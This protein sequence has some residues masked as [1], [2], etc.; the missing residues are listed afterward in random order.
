M[1]GDDRGDAAG[2]APA[3]AERKPARAAAAV[4][5]RAALPVL[6][7]AGIALLPVPNGLAANAWLYFAVFAAVIL[8]LITEPIPAAG[9]GLI[10]VTFIAVTGLA[11][12]PAQLAEPA[13]K[14][15]AEA[16]KWALAGFGNSTVWLI[17]GAFVFAMGYEKTGLGRRIALGLVRRLG[18]RTIG[19]GYAIALADVVLAPFTPSNTAR[20]A[21]TIF[22]VIRSIPE[23]Y[24]SHPGA[25]ARRIGSYLMWVAFATTCVTSSMFVTALAPN[26][27]ALELVRKITGVEITWMQWFVGFLPVGGLLVLILPWLIYKLYPPEIRMSAEVPKWAAQELAKMGG[28]TARELIMASLV[29]M[30]LGLWV[31]GGR[32]ID[33][34]LVALVA[35]SLMLVCRVFSWED[36]LGNKSAWN[37][38]A[39]FATL[40]VLADGLNKVGFVGWFGRAAAALLAGHSP[41][42]VMTTLVVLFFLIHY[43]FASLTA[44]TTAVLPVI[45]AAG[46]AVPDMPVRTFA[47]LLAF[48][49]GI[50]GVIT[51]YATGPAPVYYGSGFFTRR[52]FWT[53]GLV[54]GLIFLGALLLIGLPVLRALER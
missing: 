8:A 53:L 27:L 9:V 45:L 17:F 2:G 21:G 35:I 41:V 7:G 18:G 28:V 30:A 12:T 4:V 33:P 38:L 46:V 22:P 54:F 11:F 52:E 48:S 29:A 1:A 16:I 40:V 39:W 13:F 25:S 10:G 32:T 23:L 6:V 51:P 24:G 15:P 14:A 50:M 34:T 37:V 36:I 19:L 44:H 47:L 3:A 31:F 49:L 42:I 5:W 26:L 20:S 43:M